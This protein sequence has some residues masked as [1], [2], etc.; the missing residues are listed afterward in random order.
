VGFNYDAHHALAGQHTNSTI[1]QLPQTH[2]A[3]AYHHHHHQHH[4]HHH[5]YEISSAPITG[6]F[7]GGISIPTLS[8]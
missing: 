6:S 1:L 7:M 5:H 3:P 2:N 8:S 4:H